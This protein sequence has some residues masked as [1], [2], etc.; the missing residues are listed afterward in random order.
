[1]T[2]EG[3]DEAS[4]E[5][6][7]EFA[8]SA[9]A[10]SEQE[11]AR[12][13]EVEHQLRWLKN[14]LFGTKSERRVDLDDTTQLSL[15]EAVTKAT[16]PEEAPET[17]VREH[18]RRKSNRKQGDQD[19]PGLRF[20]DSVP[21]QTTVVVDPKFEGIPEDELEVISEKKSYQLAQRPA[22]YVV[23]ETIRPVMKRKG[24]GEVS[25]APAPPSVLPGT[26]ADVSLLAGM[27]VDKF[28]YHLP[29]YR[30][31]QRIEAAG[32]TVSRASLTN[33]THDALDL[34]EPIYNAQLRSILNSRVLAMDETPIRAGRKPRSGSSAKK[35]KMKTGYFWPV[36]GDQDEVAFPF[37]ASRAKKEAEE[38][39]GEYC[40]TLLT[41]GYTAYERWAEK[42]KEVTHALCWSH[43]RRGFVKAEEV[44]PVRSA[45]ALRR[46][47]DLY[48]ID[49][50]IR[51]KKLE[52]EEK[53]VERGQRSKPLV[54]KF[55]EWLTHEM[56]TS[57][58]LP[59]NPF[60]KAARYAL[61]REKGLEV[62][63]S[64][65]DVPMDTNHLERAL[66]PIPM[67]K[68]NWMFCWTEVGAEKVGWAQTLIATCRIH[69][70]DPY[71]YLVD[72]LQRIDTHPQ[73]RVEEL[74]P[75]RWKDCFG[76]QPMTS[77]IV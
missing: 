15:G 57:A 11:K 69:E 74:T 77:R 76:D 29:L 34:L 12:R 65:P 55:F 58:L 3:L 26:Y 10:S 46:I 43:T 45:E 9:H 72:V 30:Q 41:D 50:E 48:V 21:V 31:H 62:Y 71:T 24:T 75:R 27:V 36:Y 54:A 38:I 16:D 61:D 1:M 23:L 33:W 68:K 4:R 56:A 52:G 18:A 22:S 73:S 35:G 39:L 5:E 42:R 32:I 40:G 63:L 14:Q 6:L 19:E 64:D 59:T 70:I 7:I 28:A 25:C 47:R 8:L 2:R 13:V 20:D 44:E 66:R 67:G 51:S 17:V 53:Q 49:K 60:T 37:A